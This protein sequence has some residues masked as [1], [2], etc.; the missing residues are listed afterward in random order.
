MHHLIKKGDEM[1]N[2]DP[3]PSSA[4]ED[5]PRWAATDEIQVDELAAHDV[6][7]IST[8]NSDYE[9]VVIHPETAQVLVR[10]GRYFL[11]YTP[12]H[13]SGSSSNSSIKLHGI[14]VGY[15]IEFF[16]GSRR[17]KTSAVR[18][19]RVLRESKLAA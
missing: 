3:K 19:I 6:L 10:G 1:N 18:N 5:D 9:I 7:S 2:L 15:G 11:D 12:V 14:C 8:A 16:I 13:L 4:R 17:I